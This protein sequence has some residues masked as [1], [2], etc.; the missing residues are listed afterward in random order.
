MLN[1]VGILTHERF[2]KWRRM[3]IFLIFLVCG[4]VNPSP[5]PYTM[6]LL[7]GISVILVEFA[8]VFVYFN[9]KRRARRNVSPYAD[10]ADDQIAPLDDAD[11]REPV[12]Q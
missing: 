4:I 5:D 2:R 10:L 7:G 6:L 12:D 3:M 9:D 11:T 8:E 1:V